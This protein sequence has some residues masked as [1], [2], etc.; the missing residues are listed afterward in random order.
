MKRTLQVAGKLHTEQ[1]RELGADGLLEGEV[2]LEGI[3]DPRDQVVSQC[4]G[5]SRRWLARTSRRSPRALA[6]HNW[7]SSDSDTWTLLTAA[8]RHHRSRRRSIVL[9]S[10]L[11]AAQRELGGTPV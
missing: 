11:L 1:I 10:K 6:R 7:S 8:I 2:L 5:R 9:E 3:I 4:V